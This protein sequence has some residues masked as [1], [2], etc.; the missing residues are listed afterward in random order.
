MK[1]KTRKLQN[2]N[3][4]VSYLFPS[5]RT[6]LL[7]LKVYFKAYNICTSV[8]IL[9]VPQTENVKADLLLSSSIN[10][11]P[12]WNTL[13]CRT[14]YKNVLSFA[15]FGAVMS[16]ALSWKQPSHHV[17]NVL[18]KCAFCLQRQR[19]YF[20]RN[21]SIKY[22]KIWA[23]HRL[24]GQLGMC[25]HPPLF[26]LSWGHYFYSSF[27]HPY[28]P[29]IISYHVISF[30]WKTTHLLGSSMRNAHKCYSPAAFDRAHVHVSLQTQ[31]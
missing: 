30:S 9:A 19:N 26:G 3:I 18:C 29:P 21:P 14:G 11:S 7:F 5:C 6:R 8:S 17:C 24:S 25:I 4:S 16:S 2:S 23:W 28:V 12:G 31:G 27:L 20:R 15:H 1:I 10:T 13:F 22:K